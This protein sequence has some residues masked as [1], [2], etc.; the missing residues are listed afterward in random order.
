MKSANPLWIPVVLIA[1]SMQI[2]CSGS[3][4]NTAVEPKEAVSTVDSAASTGRK[5]VL[6]FFGNSLTAGY[7]LESSESFPS[8]IQA[9][10]DSLGHEYE[11]INA[12]VSGETTATGSNRIDW[13]AERA[14]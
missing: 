8:L 5:K 6:L 12:G 3:G 1:F 2:S 11:V 9:K 7:G 13:V 4:E 14:R 10:L